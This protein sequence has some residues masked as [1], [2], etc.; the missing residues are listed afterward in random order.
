MTGGVINY[1][2]RPIDCELTG[3]CRLFFPFPTFLLSIST[4]FHF[5]FFL[6]LLLNVEL[7]SVRSR[8]LFGSE[9]TKHI[10]AVDAEYL[11]RN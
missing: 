2:L 10:F 4:S 9:N 3:L 5:S 1:V 6:P 7:N 11:P 8:N